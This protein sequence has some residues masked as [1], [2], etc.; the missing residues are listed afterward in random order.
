MASQMKFRL[1]RILAIALLPAG[2]VHA[3]QP[4]DTIRKPAVFRIT[5]EVINANVIPFTATIGGFGNTLI[6]KGAGF[7]PV[8]FRN[9]LI[10]LEDSPGRVIADPAT[11][12]RY[13][14]LREGFLDQATVHIY[15]IENGRFRMVREDRVASGGSHASGWV[16]AIG[17]NQVVPPGV[18]RLGFRWDN[19]NRPGARYY[20]TV[21]AIDKYGNLSPAAPA[22]EIDSPEKHDKAPAPH[23]A[24]IAFKPAKGLFSRPKPLSAPR[25]LRGKLGRD[26]ILTLEWEPADST[27]LAGY[28]VYRS[29]YPPPQHREHYLQLTGTPASP[30]QRI[31]AGD[32]VIVSKKIYSL[33][34]NRDLS[35]RV[36]GAESAY[37]HLMPGLLQFFPDESPAKTWS[38]VP[39]AANTPVEEPGETCLKLQLGAGTRE[40]LLIYNHGGTGQS[41]YDVLEKK[42]YTVEV[43]LRQEGSGTVQFKLAGFYDTA[44][45]K[46]K[47]VVFNVSHGWKKYVAH[48]T[49][50]VIQGEPH[51]GAMVLEFTG[52]ATFYVDNFRVYRADTAYLDFLPRELEAIKSSGISALRTHGLIKTGV[53]TYD[54]EQLTN[55]GGVISGTH[56]VP[57]EPP[58]VAGLRRVHG[59]AL[60]S[61]C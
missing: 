18:T 57:H 34:R 43:W 12:S 47:P 4:D 2:A 21:R 6:G 10:A 19:W 37:K 61:E 38:L 39:H 5:T 3:D 59:R 32:M 55:S 8:V 54:M 50:P 17:K 25:A 33:S 7:E 30:D 45:Q 51:P 44:P 13:D 1:A 49:P 35:N 22:F 42:T 23:N 36:W 46:I 20:F 41:W 26:G 28:V 52:P 31:K 60:R 53:H 16:R 11:M 29:D 56:R 48:F 9:K 24:L 58:G 15:R 40:S 27:D 14:I